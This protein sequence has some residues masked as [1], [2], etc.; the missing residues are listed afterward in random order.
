MLNDEKHQILKLFIDNILIPRIIKIRKYY[1][2][3]YNIEEG[4]FKNYRGLSYDMSIDLI[5]SLQNYFEKN[6]ELKYQLSYEADILQGHQ[7]RCP[8]IESHDWMLKHTWV[9]VKIM[10]KP[11]YIDLSSQEFKN[12]YLDI[13]DYYISFKKPKWYS[14]SSDNKMIN[15][16]MNVLWNPISDSIHRIIYR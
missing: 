13:P 15:Y 10:N 7:K 4:C 5:K 1:S 16:L 3:K 12:I 6:D 14:E 8:R 2:D 11:I 9:Y